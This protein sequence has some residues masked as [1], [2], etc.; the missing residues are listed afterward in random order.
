M[1]LVEDQPDLR[2][3]IGRALEG[4]GLEVVAFEGMESAEVGIQAYEG[5]PDLFITDIALGDG[6][7]LDLAERLLNDGRVER[8]LIT[9]GNADFDRV[10]DLTSRHGCRVL[11]KPFRIRQLYQLV[12]EILSL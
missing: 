3:L 4:L 5:I 11:M 7:G 6:N 8:V 9:T 10:E 1:V 2:R 12:G